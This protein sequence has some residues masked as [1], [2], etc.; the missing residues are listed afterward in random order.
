MDLV[1]Y[2][3]ARACKKRVTG[4]QPLG[5]ETGVTSPHRLHD[6][7]AVKVVNFVHLSFKL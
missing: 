4:K 1:F 5:W 6:L 2:V 3:R 7:N